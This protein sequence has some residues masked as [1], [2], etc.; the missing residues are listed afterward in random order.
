MKL[1]NKLFLTFGSLGFFGVIISAA[2]ISNNFSDTQ[3]LTD[4]SRRNIPKIVALENIKAT[5]VQLSTEAYRYSLFKFGLATTSLNNQ[6][7]FYR[8]I[9]NLK[10][11]NKSLEFSIKNLEKL[12]V[13][14][15]E[16]E[17]I[18]ELELARKNFYN[19]VEKL[20]TSKNIQTKNKKFVVTKEELQL[21]ESQLLEIIE[22]EIIEE[23]R[24]LDQQE[25]A[26]K[27][28]VYQTILINSICLIILPAMCGAAIL[29]F[30]IK[31]VN[32]L[33]K[34]K[35]SIVNFKEKNLEVKLNLEEGKNEIQII[36]DAFN[37][38]GDVLSKK[39]VSQ[40]YL[41]NIL[42]SMI[43][44]LIILNPDKTIKTFN[45][46]TFLML[47]Y[48][49]EDELLGKSVNTLFGDDQFLKDLE[50]DEFTQ[51][52][53]FLGRKETILLAK[54]NR[55]IPVYFSASVI[56][57]QQGNVEGF[58]C[59]AQDISDRKK[60]ETAMQES[61][62]KWRSLVEN[63]PDIILTSDKNGLIQFINREVPE[64]GNKQLI[65]TSIYDWVK[66]ED[67]Q[68]LQE[69]IQLVFATGEPQ[70]NEV[71]G[72]KLDGT[73][74]WYANRIGP[75]FKNG[76]VSAI[77]I[78]TTDITERKRI[79]QALRESEEKLESILKSLTDVVWSVEPKTRKVLYLNSA[80][81]KVYGRP[82]S[83]FF[84]N[85]KLWLEIIHPEDIEKFQQTCKTVLETGSLEMEYRIIRPNGEIRWLQDRGKLIYALDGTPVR[86]DGIAT[87]ITERKNAEQALQ[88]IN[89]DLELRVQDRTKA[90][91][92]TNKRLKKEIA[93]RQV[94]TE[95]L[96]QSEERL[97]SI[98]NS[99]DDVVWSIDAVTFE[100][101]YLSPA[102]EKIY[103]CAISDFFNDP[104]LWSNFIHP[105]DRAYVEKAT[106][107]LLKNGFVEFEYR[108]MRGDSEI[109]WLGSQSRLVCDKDGKPIRMDGIASDITSRKAAEALV[110][111][112]E[113]R[114]RNLA[115]REAVINKLAGQ[116]R[117]SL[118]LNTILDT[119]VRSIRNLL[120][121]D[122]CL[123]CWY[124]PYSIGVQSTNSINGISVI[125]EP[126]TS[127]VAASPYWEVAHEA[128]NPIL[129]SYLGHYLVEKESFL[130]DKL[131]KLE[132]IRIDDLSKISD[133]N[134]EIIGSVWGY[135]SILILPL[136]TK[137]GEIGL[138]SCGSHSSARPWRE[139]E[140]AL[141]RSISDQL[142]IAI[143]QAELYN[144]ATEAA[145]AAKEQAKQLQE[146][147]KA[148]QQTQAQ[149]I[150]TEKMSSLGQM[151]AGIAHEINNPVSF[152]Y[153]NVDPAMQYIQDLLNL[154]ELY[155]EEYSPTPSIVEEIEAIDLEFLKQDLPKLLGSLKLGADRIRQIVLSLRN[156]SRLDEA[157]MKAVNLH[158]GIDS[159][160]LILQNRLKPKGNNPE[161]Q[162]IKNYRDLPSVECFAGQLNQVF[163]NILANA[164]DALEIHS[165]EKFTDKNSS[166]AKAIPVINITTNMIDSN[167]VKI[168]ISDNGCGMS[169]E[170]VSR[171]FD[172]FFTTK[173]VGS[174]TGLGLSISYQIV[175]DKHKGVLKCISKLGEGTQFIIELPVCQ[176]YAEPA[177][178][179]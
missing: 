115:K 32:P 121:I 134:L 18:E 9:E 38:M 166:M 119:A 65:G 143:S 156:F 20:I 149:L 21:A 104:K 159:T 33:R 14:T 49:R 66:L 131:L 46:A 84:N 96:R 37:Q 62:A 19:L 40:F 63:A 179:K 107:K 118:E 6:D 85:A 1:Q 122:R 3:K 60:A 35:Q 39:I 161:I 125:S 53:S 7:F 112:S 67:R 113:A 123:F 22:K 128:R 152:I 153:G 111:S 171:I 2:N 73:A 82:V 127:I 15:E 142:S 98:L 106:Q 101:L 155:Q 88:K 163:M 133:S 94:V 86:I 91:K 12:A 154:V 27:D 140:I 61:E 124:R 29:F 168:C 55:E 51:N 56:R 129:P 138:L 50:N 100:V 26:F 146:A 11:Y 10:K 13:S 54:N 57:D 41:D 160:L 68:Q 31:M 69:S 117:N 120:Q 95:A 150:Q 8:D 167:Q 174:G 30:S 102:V 116:I 151:V 136:Q 44:A 36:A 25:K 17:N 28:K 77:T 93:E 162:V 64:L 78:I 16:I 70:Y 108:I 109:R 176:N 175:V 148:L 52:N 90:I 170:V 135:H 169:D 145:R 81:E 157:Q 87:D 137:S 42:R 165:S 177:L 89:E 144:H 139:T 23:L 99:I 5:S 75:I 34:I 47:G 172:P 80:T 130:S 79:E 71:S 178:F 24:A 126:S 74:T 72:F 103:G 83:D 105:E 45:L 158:E 97:N 76:E 147:M 43:D 114:F 48:D 4:I 92:Q 59:L 110:K 173:P 141:L 58:V 132:M 164:I